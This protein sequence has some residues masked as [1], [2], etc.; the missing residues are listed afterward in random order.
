MQ[1]SRERGLEL[2]LVHPFR[3]WCAVGGPRPGAGPGPA[4]GLAAALTRLGAT[5]SDRSLAVLAHLELMGVAVVNGWRAAALARHKFL[6]LQALSRA[7]LP[8]LESYLVG[9]RPG[10]AEAVER[11]GGPPVVVKLASARQGAG[12][13]LVREAGD[14]PLIDGAPLSAFLD[15]RRGAVVQR[16]LPAE[17]RREFRVLVVGG[18]ALA[19]AEARPREGEF[20][21][22]LHQGASLSPA[23]PGPELEGLALRAAAALGLEVAGVDIMQDAGGATVVGEVNLSPGFRGLEEATGVDAA[24]AMVE[25]LARRAGASAPET[26]QPLA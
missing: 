3:L 25:L 19:A 15:Q 11:L 21:A 7:G 10:Y 23:R 18:R 26:I 4:A 2:E 20:R 12:V 9:D 1:A 22:N 17:G 16:H 6:G 14:D 13:F 24:G 8:V 5:L